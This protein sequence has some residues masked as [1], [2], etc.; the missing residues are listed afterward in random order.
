M[1]MHPDQLH[2]DEQI[3]RQLIAEQFPQWRDESVVHIEGGG[4]VNAIF[5]IG[6]NVAARFPLNPGDP[7]DAVAGHRKEAAAMSELAAVCPVPTPI[8]AAH[9]APGE[10]YPLPW[11]SSGGCPW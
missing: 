4:T 2:V 5:R 1:K 8:H 11:T 3:A 6:E 9:G 7:V 10:A